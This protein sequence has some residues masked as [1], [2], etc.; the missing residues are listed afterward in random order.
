MVHRNSLTD[1]L[2]TIICLIILVGTVI[3]LI[4]SWSSIPDQIPG[5]F[6]ADGTVARWD[7][8][9]ILVIAPI[10]S[11]VLFLGMSLVERFPQVWNTGVRVTEENQFRVY[12][13]VKGLIRT[14]KLATVILFSVIVIIQSTA[15]SLPGWLMPVF[16]AALAILII[17]HIIRLIMAR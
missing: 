5:Q 17:Y 14:T 7:S 2:V 9:G 3:Y 15:Q 6:S 8:K 12:R 13:A 11:W 16:L 1:I 10:I 4:V